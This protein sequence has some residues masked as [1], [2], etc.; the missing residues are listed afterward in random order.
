[1]KTLE[2]KRTLKFKPVIIDTSIDYDNK[3]LFLEKLARA[4]EMLA[5]SG[6]LPIR[7]LDKTK[8]K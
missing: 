5:K 7:S 6:P 8:Q 2:N 1:M 4:K 3:T